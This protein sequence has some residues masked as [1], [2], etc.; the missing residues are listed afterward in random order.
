MPTGLRR[1]GCHR[2]PPRPGDD[3]QRRPPGPEPRGRTR[4]GLGGA[5]SAGGVAAAKMPACHGGDRAHRRGRFAATRRPSARGPS[6]VRADTLV[7]LVATTRLYYKRVFV[8]YMQNALHNTYVMKCMLHIMKN[9][10]HIHAYICMAHLPCA[11]HRHRCAYL[12]SKIGLF[13]NCLATTEVSSKK[14]NTIHRGE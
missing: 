5:G 9:R 12:T 2:A 4:D 6:A 1:E 10:K 3:A 14:S 13:H 11:F 8:R 7:W